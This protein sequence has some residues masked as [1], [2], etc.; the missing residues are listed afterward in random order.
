MTTQK[1]NEGRLLIYAPV[2]V[3]GTPDGWVV[4][5][6]AANGLRLWAE[7]FDHVTVMMPHQD[8]PPPT[9]WVPFDKTGENAARITIVALPTAWSLAKFAKTY[10]NTKAIIRDQI[11]RA[12]YL[13]FAIGGL[14]GDWGAVA[15][16]QAHKMGR[17]FAAWTDR[18]ESQ[19]VKIEAT[20]GPLKSRIKKRVIHR[21]MA[22]LERYVIRRAALGLF[23]GQQTY[24]TYAPYCGNP[25]MVHDIHIGRDAHISEGAFE[26]KQAS[27]AKDPLRI[28]Y[29]G[30]ATAMKGPLFWATT[31]QKLDQAGIPFEAHWLG[32]GPMLED[33]RAQLQTDGLLEKTTLHGFVDD[34]D[35]VAAQMQAAH[36]FLFCHTTPES[37]RCLIESLIA[38]TPIVGF[39]GA[40]AA[41]LI[42]ASGGGALVDV[43]DTDGLAKILIGLAQDR[44]KLT[45]LINSARQ[46]GAPFDD[47]S[48]F[49]HRSDLIKRHLDPAQHR[50]NTT[51]TVA[52][53]A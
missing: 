21:P 48:V 14:V 39:D 37:P 33:M 27:A 23:H 29:A 53:T 31:L 6:Q 12:D 35:A 13:S 43:G 22:F 2:P 19:V 36:V 46:D 47:V 1:P 45:H 25:Q 50:H 8:G 10:R 42:A 20:S 11:N 18:V 24:D 30:R 38:G 5:R 28:V 51:D 40:Y 16:L 49:K 32:D 44:D 9:G 4:E 34:A 17:R 26:A 7:N 15:S 52:K 41:D 3:F